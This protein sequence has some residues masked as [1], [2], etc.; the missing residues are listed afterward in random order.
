MYFQNHGN[1]RDLKIAFIMKGFN[2]YPKPNYSD[3]IRSLQ[4]RSEPKRP[5][6]TR[7]P[8]I[9]NLKRYKCHTTQYRAPDE[10]VV[11][12]VY[13]TRSFDANGTIGVPS[14]NR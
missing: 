4:L 13:S 9:S 7:L 3:E 12:V 14:E 2:S 10:P 11:K 8:S 5:N 6:A 1:A